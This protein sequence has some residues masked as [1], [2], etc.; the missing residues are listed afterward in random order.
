MFTE[1]LMGIDGRNAEFCKHGHETAVDS[2]AG[3]E[4]SGQWVTDAEISKCF[5][6]IPH[7]RLR[8]VLDLR[9][10]DVVV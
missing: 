1:P 3:E 2:R 10:R 9:I 4:A 5:D 7:N 6:G 8:E